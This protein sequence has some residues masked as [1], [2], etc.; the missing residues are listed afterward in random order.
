MSKIFDIIND[1]N[2][3]Y[4]TK[5][6]YAEDYIKMSDKEQGDLCKDVRN[7]LVDYVNSNEYN[8]KDIV[9]NLNDYAAS[10]I[11]IFY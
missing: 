4:Q 1:L 9:S 8:F 3:C 10:M 6:P 2:N 5:A 7:Q 11:H